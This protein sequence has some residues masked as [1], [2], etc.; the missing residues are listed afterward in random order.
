MKLISS[1]DTDV[2][3]YFQKVVLAGVFPVLDA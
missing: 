2:Y 3:L 1:L